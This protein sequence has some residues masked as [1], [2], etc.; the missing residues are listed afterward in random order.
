MNNTNI[1][2]TVL[3][4]EK[5]KVKVL[6]DCVHLELLPGSI[7]LACCILMYWKGHSISRFPPVLTLT[8]RGSW[9]THPLP[10]TV[11]LGPA[12]KHMNLEASE[13]PA[14]LVPWQQLRLKFIIHRKLKDT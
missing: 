12:F 14:L 10:N 4:G 2:V 3:K 13:H 7:A 5:S 6:E 8:P 1:S 9:P 11:V